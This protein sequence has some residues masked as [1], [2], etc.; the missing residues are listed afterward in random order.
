L[1]FFLIKISNRLKQKIPQVITPTSGANERRTNRWSNENSSSQTTYKSNAN[2]NL[3][4]TPTSPPLSPTTPNTPLSPN[5][6][7]QTATNIVSPVGA[8]LLN[9]RG[10]QR[11][12]TANVG[13]N[14][15]QKQTQNTS[16]NILGLFFFVLFLYYSLKR[17]ILKQWEIFFG[18]GDPFS[19]PRHDIF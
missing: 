2:L 19:N 17:S 11:W 18:F 10:N 6:N 5:K 13:G 4:N 12:E 14:T 7:Q 8:K 1:F 9:N 15:S 3:A 16:A